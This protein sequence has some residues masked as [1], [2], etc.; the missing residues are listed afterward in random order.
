MPLIRDKVQIIRC[1]GEFL[2]EQ[3]RVQLS[4]HP[5]ENRRD[6]FTIAE[7]L[8][9]NPATTLFTA[10][11]VIWVEGPTERLFLRHWLPKRLEEKKIYEGFHYTLMQ[12]GG[13]LISHLDACD[14][15]DAV[16]AFDLMSICRYPI[17]LVDSDLTE[18]SENRNR[19]DILKPGAKRLASQIDR[20]NERRPNA[21]LFLCTWGREIENYL[22]PKAIA[23]AVKTLYSYDEK[24]AEAIKLETTPFPR[25][26]HYY[27]FIEKELVA[28]GIVAD[29]EQN[30]NGEDRKPKA[31]GRGKW[32][33]KKKVNFMRTALACPDLGERDL[34]GDAIGLLDQIAAHIERH[35]NLGADHPL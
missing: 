34:Q 5:V 28:V 2:A 24:E 11:V 6:A 25:F 22:P 30:E 18:S 9:L 12:Y 23:H 17:V 8:G 7:R 32:G 19:S 10:N 13:G 3:T 33:E 20:L 16:A 26:E 4:T 15:A 31:K 1:E 21:A 27:D 29:V 35:A 14:D